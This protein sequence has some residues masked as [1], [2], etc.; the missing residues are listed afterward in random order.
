MCYKYSQDLNKVGTECPPQNCRP[1]TRVCFRYVLATRDPDED[2][3]PPLIMKPKRK[4]KN[5]NEECSGYA[6][7]FFMTVEKMVRHFARMRRNRPNISQ[8][9]GDHIAQGM[10]DKNDG[11]QTQPTEQGHFDLHEYVGVRLS[12]K[13]KA[14]QELPE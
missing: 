6:L 11:V 13:F 12:P 9:L 5:T 7:S 8:T 2:F 1:E 3:L 4:F 14:V 10:L